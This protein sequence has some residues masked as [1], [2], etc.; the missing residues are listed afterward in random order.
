[1]VRWHKAIRVHTFS[2]LILLA[3]THAAHAQNSRPI[4]FAKP[5]AVSRDAASDDTRPSRQTLLRQIGFEAQQQ[6]YYS[7]MLVAQKVL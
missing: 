2:S 6:G 5:V 7:G 3:F 4:S 1:M